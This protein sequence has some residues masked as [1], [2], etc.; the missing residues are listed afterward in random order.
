MLGFIAWDNNSHSV[1]DFSRKTG[2]FATLSVVDLKVL[3]L[4]YML[5]VQAKWYIRLRTEP[6]KVCAIWD[7][8]RVYRDVFFSNCAGGVFFQTKVNKKPHQPIQ[9]EETE[10]TAEAQ[11]DDGWEVAGRGKHKAH[12]I[13]VQ[14]TPTVT[15]ALQN[16]SVEDTNVPIAEIDEVKDSSAVD[17][18]EDAPEEE[19]TSLM[20]KT[21]RMLVNGSHPKM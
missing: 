7:N 11:D 17:E 21:M 12:H 14:E 10:E 3:A 15:E 18:S 5:E 16:L 13:P 20:M 6:V 4:T 2:D 8:Q 1:V 19:I 9:V